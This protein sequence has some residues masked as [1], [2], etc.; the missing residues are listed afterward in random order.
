MVVTSDRL[1]RALLGADGV[2][3]DFL[4][5]AVAVMCHLDLESGKAGVSVKLTVVSVGFP[6]AAAHR[7]LMRFTLLRDKKMCCLFY[8]LYKVYTHISQHSSLPL[9]SFLIIMQNNNKI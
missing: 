1:L 6:I 4:T 3:F 7:A 8:C 5:S 2:V 9:L